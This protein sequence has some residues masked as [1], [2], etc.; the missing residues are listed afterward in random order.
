MVVVGLLQTEYGYTTPRGIWNARNNAIFKYNSSIL[1]RV[2]AKVLVHFEILQNVEVAYIARN[3]VTEKV[4][5][6]QPWAYFD[7]AS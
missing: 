7:G 5:T 3:I 6:S 1:D 2:A 4:D